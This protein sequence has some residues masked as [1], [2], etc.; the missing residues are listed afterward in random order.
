MSAERCAKCADLRVRYDIR[1]PAELTKAIH[2]IRDNLADGTLK[3]ITQPAHSP[4][5]NFRDL[6]D[7]APWPDYVEHYFR[8]S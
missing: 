8:C 2:V 5:G 3:D 6:P 1:T 4:S 7:K